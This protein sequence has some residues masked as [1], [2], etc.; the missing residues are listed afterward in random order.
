M[1]SPLMVRR[2]RASMRARVNARRA[3]KMFRTIAAI[4]S[5]Y[6]GHTYRAYLGMKHSPPFIA[7]AVRD[8]RADGI[9][10]AIGIVMAPHWS[11][12]SVETYLERVRAEAG[13]VGP[14][15]TFVRWSLTMVYGWNTYERIWLPH[16]I[17]AFDASTF[18]RSASFFS[19]SR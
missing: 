1:S 2:R 16:A 18:A 9:E 6:D 5:P 4:T 11:A 12:M 8:M 13:D 19:T 17:S 15:F 14:I 7:E 3:Q 10:R